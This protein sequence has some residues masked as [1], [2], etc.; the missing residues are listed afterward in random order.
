MDLGERA[1]GFKYLIR[2]R[3]GQFTAA[4]DAVLAD[5]G[6]EVLEIPAG[7]LRANDLQPPRTDHPISAL[8]AQRIAHRTV[9]GG[10]I[11]EYQPAASAPS[12]GAMTWWSS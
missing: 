2:D 5:A 10:L 11:N 1:E 7:R 6:T 3:A 8:P 9:L 4:F 12:A